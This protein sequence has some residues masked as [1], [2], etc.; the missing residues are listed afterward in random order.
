MANCEQGG[1]VLLYEMKPEKYS[2][3]HRFPF[4]AEIVCSNSFKSESLENGP[5]I[6][7]EELG[8]L[9]SLILKTARETRVS[10][11]GS[12]A[13]DREA[14]SRKITHVLEGLEKVKIVRKEI[15][16]IPED[17]TVIIATGPLTSE[18]LSGEIRKLTET[19]TSSSMMLSRRSLPLIRSISTEF[20]VP[21][22]TEKEEAITSIAR[23]ERTRI[24]GLWMR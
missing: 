15:S 18:S 3:A 21:P 10:A 9:D 5:G 23:W 12:L 1:E 13:V 17:G 11:G 19:A 22:V 7:K 20:S 4:F 8:R 24:T 2:P 14:F 16:H 6:L